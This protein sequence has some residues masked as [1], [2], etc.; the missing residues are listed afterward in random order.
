M[1]MMAGKFRLLYLLD[2]LSCVLCEKV[3]D[4]CGRLLDYPANSVR[5]LRATELEC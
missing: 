4:M 5:R 3:Q 2:R 1:T